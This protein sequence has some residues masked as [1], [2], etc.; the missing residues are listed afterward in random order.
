MQKFKLKLMLILLLISS[1][2]M[3]QQR[4][5]EG[6]VLDE[7]GSSFPG[8][9][10]SI[11]GTTT[12]MTTGSDGKYSL[13]VNA[14]NAVLVFRFLGY[15][16]KEE[17]VGNRTAVNVTMVPD[18]IDAGEVVVVAYG[19]QDTKSITGSVTSLSAEKIKD[20]PISNAI[21]ALGGSGPG[22]QVTTA[23][24]Q[25]GD[26]PAI[27]LRGIGSVNGNNS[28]FIV[29]DGVPFS[30]NINRINPDDIESVSTLKDAASTSLYGA[31]AAN[32]V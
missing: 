32:G 29:V 18:V 7:F 25:P 6:T 10:V 21:S 31:R 1:S 2:V 15:K 22:I 17:T 26:S 5:V 28:P 23:T 11:K 19:T 3:G 13:S 14:D 27:R 4:T 8:V 9:T 24:G 12:G 30:G 16:T 20:R